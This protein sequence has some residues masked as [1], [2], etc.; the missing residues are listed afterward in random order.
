MTNVTL[1]QFKLN[2][3]VDN[4]PILNNDEQNER[5]DYNKRN[6]GAVKRQ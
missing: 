2:N 1:N 6:G 3:N 4:Q 5:N